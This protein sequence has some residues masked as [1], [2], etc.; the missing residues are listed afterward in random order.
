MKTFF[1]ILILFIS[2]LSAS[3]QFQWVTHHP[4]NLY[5]I[6]L[7]KFFTDGGYTASSIQYFNTDIENV[8]LTIE[9]LGIGKMT[10]L[11]QSYN[12]DIKSRK[13]VTYSMYKP[14]Y[15]VISGI[16]KGEYF[17]YKTIIKTG[18]IH[19]LKLTYPKNQ[20]ILFDAVLSRIVK[21]FI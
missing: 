10:T 18:N 8:T 9:S 14:T 13:N 7:P 11:N 19:Y 2:S 17:Y 21:S 6:D 12:D 15:Y 16:D 1:P 20:K 3:A 5:S 4:R